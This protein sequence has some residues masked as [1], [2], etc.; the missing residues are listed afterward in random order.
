MKRSSW[1][2]LAVLLVSCIGNAQERTDL[3]KGEWFSCDRW[4]FHAGDTINLMRDTCEINYLT[5]AIAVRFQVNFEFA[6]D[7]FSVSTKSEVIAGATY[8]RYWKLSKD[9]RILISNDQKNILEA[10]QL[11]YIDPKN[12]ILLK[13]K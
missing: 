7:H 13:M 8:Y 2:L 9:D 4:V 10:Y 1:S 5:D 12:L 6:E 11:L 3:I